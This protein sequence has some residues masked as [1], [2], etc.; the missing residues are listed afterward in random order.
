MS[1]HLEI[2]LKSSQR[3]FYIVGFKYKAEVNL[4]KV[5]KSLKVRIKK[6]F[7]H[8]ND[9]LRYNIWNLLILSNDQY[10]SGK[11]DFSENNDGKAPYVYDTILIE[12]KQSNTVLFMFPSKLLGLKMVSKLMSGNEYLSKGKFIK[13]DIH[14]LVKSIKSKDIISTHFSAHL[15]SVGLKL[16]DDIELSR[17]KLEG[18]RPLNTTLYKET[19][20]KLI[21]KDE[22]LADLCSVK[23]DLEENH[24]SELPNTTAS[25]NMDSYGNFKCYIHSS[26]LN[27]HSFPLML[28]FLNEKKCIEQTSLNPM[29][30][31]SE[32]DQ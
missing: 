29:N 1:D 32:D 2:N 31:I 18:D 8:S 12:L 28:G 27:L 17:I 19:F 26:G 10:F 30:K 25:I 20:L 24:L 23:I 5:C 3:Y 15:S 9:K 16:N 14:K 7:K 11:Q 13:P 22:Y 6:T 4:N 21:N